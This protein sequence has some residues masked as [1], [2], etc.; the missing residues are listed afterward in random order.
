VGKPRDY[1]LVCNMTAINELSV[2]SNF[3]VDI[4]YGYIALHNAASSNKFV[5]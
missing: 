1:G 3:I 2:N 5:D 4:G